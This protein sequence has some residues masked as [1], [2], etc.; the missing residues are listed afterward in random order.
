MRL[1]LIV[2]AV[3][4]STSVQID[5]NEGQQREQRGLWDLIFLPAKIA[6]GTTNLA[7]DAGIGATSLALGAGIGATK[8]AVDAGIEA[9]G[10]ALDAGKA[11]NRGKP[12]AKKLKINFHINNI[13]SGNREKL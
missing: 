3:L 13:C 10:L 1:L 8:F 12:V 4:V 7:I 11:V 6:I 9:T 5:S 2:V